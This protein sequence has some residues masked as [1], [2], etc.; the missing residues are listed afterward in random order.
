MGTIPTYVTTDITDTTR[1]ASTIVNVIDIA[2]ESIKP[3]YYNYGLY[4]YICEICGTTD[5]ISEKSMVTEMGDEDDEIIDINGNIHVH[6][7]WNYG[8]TCLT[9]KNYHTTSQPYVFTCECGWNSKNGISNVKFKPQ[10]IFFDEPKDEWE[11]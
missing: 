3:I 4:T 10:Y 8:T 2:S 6:E 11:N 5:F 7:N 9:C 1:T